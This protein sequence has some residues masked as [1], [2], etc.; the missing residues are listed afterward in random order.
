M[1]APLLRYSSVSDKIIDGALFAFA[2]GTNPEALVLVE[3]V[4]SETGR[5]WRAAP[6]RLSGY[7]MRGWHKDRL[8]L[9][10]EKVQP[11]IRTASLFQRSRTVSPFSFPEKSE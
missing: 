10:V 11:A 5:V 8:V 2:Q 7:Q 6:S 3:A 4:E 1:P 9:D